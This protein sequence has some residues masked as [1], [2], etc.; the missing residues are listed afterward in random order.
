[1]TGRPY[2]AERDLAAVTRM[3]RE[4]GWIDDSDGQARALRDLLGCGRSL[5]ADVAG[6]AECLVHTSPGSIR[7]GDVDLPLCAVTAVTT[8]HVARRRGLASSLVVESLRAAA[9]DGAAVAA[10]GMFDQGFYDRF[11]FGTGSYEHEITFDPATLEV[12][13]PERAPVRL[14]PEDVA[15]MHALLV[16]RHRGHGSVVIDPAR[17]FAAEL[18]WTAKPYALGFR[19]E[20][21]RLTHFLAGSAE[22]GHGPYTVD[23]VAFEEPHQILELLGL[24]KALGDQVS[25][26]TFSAEPAEVQLQDLVRTPIRQLRGARLSGAGARHHALAEQQVRIL[27]LRACIEAVHLR[28]PPVELG[29]RLR[30]PLPADAA[31]GWAGVAGDHT[32][33]LGE[34][35]TLS[36][37]ITTAAPVLEASV[38]A[39]SRLW[40]GARPA[41][42]LAL[43]DELSAP[44]GLLHQLDESLTYPPPLAGWTF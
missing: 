11:G 34:E 7:H 29:L 31:T 43:T 22:A 17:Q 39:F 25:A 2:H 37:G 9:A 5:V 35:S 20:D 42:S 24:L 41:S 30:D 4:V 27:D 26:V 6:Q 8:S 40:I 14:G 21:G 18:A 23:W 15:E 12:E 36:E 16:R 19:A 3:W 32:V 28:T 33:R 38:K 10:L 44:P 1:M 13:L